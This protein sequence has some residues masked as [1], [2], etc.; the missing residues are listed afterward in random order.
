M[1]ECREKTQR[2]MEERRSQIAEALLFRLDG[3]D[4]R[5]KECGNDYGG[6]RAA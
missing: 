5:R 1:E 2:V 6:G 3:D 4:G